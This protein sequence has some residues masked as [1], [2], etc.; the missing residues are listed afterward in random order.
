MQAKE[1]LNVII[2]AAGQ[3]KRMQSDK[4]KVLQ[5]LGGKPLIEHVIQ[6]AVQLAPKEILVVYGDP[7]EQIQKQLEHYPLTWVEQAERLGT[8]HA[9][10]QTLSHL[11]GN[12]RTLILF[13]DVPLISA[14]TLIKLCLETPKEG[15]GLVT[16]TID[17]PSG[18]GRII[19]NDCGEVTRIV[20]DK[21]ASEAEKTI[22]EINTGIIL[23]P[24]ERLHAWLPQNQ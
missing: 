7:N 2:L 6:T 9:V 24:T 3:G 19:R 23:I 4:P 22:N 15:M 13:G 5:D 11:V 1:A 21:D 10:K 8:G 12:G 16:A 17:D 20:E 14:E 18:L